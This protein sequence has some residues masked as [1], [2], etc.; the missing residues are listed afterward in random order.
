MTAGRST[1]VAR[2][3]VIRGSS[4]AEDRRP[5]EVLVRS[6]LAGVT[7]ARVALARVTLTG[8]P[9][10]RVPVSLA[11]VAVALARV[12][13]ALTGIAVALARVAVVRTVEAQRPTD[14]LRLEGPAV[15]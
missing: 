6:A 3:A 2:P 12:T 9:L 5:V 1:E 10:A 4:L 7:L 14:V 15:V 13:V 8:V 11:R